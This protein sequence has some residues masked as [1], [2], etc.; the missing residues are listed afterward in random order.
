[1]FVVVCRGVLTPTKG[2]RNG[3]ASINVAC[4]GLRDRPTEFDFDCA[5]PQS[6]TVET[7]IRGVDI[8]STDV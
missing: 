8:A 2:D 7:L 6:D 3:E 4:S 5:S 1:M